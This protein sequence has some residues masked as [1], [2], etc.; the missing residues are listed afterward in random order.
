MYTRSINLDFANQQLPEHISVMQGDSARKILVELYR[1]NVEWEV[2]G[3]VSAYIAFRRPDGKNLK[4]TSLSDGSPVVSLYDNMATISV[5]VE[6]TA[7]HG[8]VPLVVVFVD[9][10]GSQIATFPIAI[11]VVENPAVES[12]L[13]SQLTPKE[14]D[15]LLVEITQTNA[16]INELVASHNSEGAEEYSLDIYGDGNAYITIRSNGTTAVCTV[17]DNAIFG[18]GAVRKYQ[19][20]ERFAPPIA[21]YAYDG[22]VELCI[23]DSYD[24]YTEVVLK[25]KNQSEAKADGIW[26]QFVYALAAVYTPKELLDVRVGADGTIYETAG[27]AV[28]E[29]MKAASTGSGGGGANVGAV[30]YTKQSPTPEQQAQARENI[31]AVGEEALS[32]FRT[33]TITEVEI[34]GSTNIFN[35]AAVIPNKKLDGAAV[36]DSTTGEC[37]SETFKV[38]DGETDITLSYVTGGGVHQL[39]TFI[40]AFYDSEMKSI[41][42]MMAANSKYTIPDNAAYFI[43]NLGNAFNSVLHRIMVQYG[44]TMTAFESYVAPEISTVEEVRIKNECLDFAEITESRNQYNFETRTDDASLNTDGTLNTTDFKNL[45][46]V[47]YFIPCYGESV[48]S[49]SSAADG[50]YCF[51]DANKSFISPYGVFS[52]GKEGIAIPA[53][54]HYVRV[55]LLKANALTFVLSFTEAAVP[56]EKYGATYTSIESSRDKNN[57]KSVI[58]DILAS[59]GTIKFLGDSITQ[60]VGGTGFAQDGEEIREGWNVNTKGY[61]FANLFKTY[62]ETKYSNPVINY[63]TKGVRSYNLVSWLEA[64]DGYVTEDDKLLIVMIGTNNKWS[65]TADTLADLKN[66]IQWIV[67]WCAENGKKLILVSAPMSTVGYDTQYSDGTAV[68]FHNEDIDH[69]YKEVC[70]KNNMDYVPMY[71]RMV[72]YCDLKD[73]DIATIFDD[74]LH[75]NDKGYYIMYK[76]LM[77]ELGLAYQMPNSDWDNASPSA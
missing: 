74:G 30:L 55:S 75:P 57:C 27:E 69:V 3:D 17:S 1:N 15:Q 4:I 7:M 18:M 13:A 32:E 16:R 64:K 77:K 73:I 46:S 45:R 24:G 68:K 48:F 56:Y 53:T 71:Q 67:D 20:P 28:R 44:D 12:D 25:N 41:V 2:P 66:D 31:G 19:L 10:N 36:V 65:T 8:A 59:G 54:A 60:G 34:G 5:P 42:P 6:V 37:V 51:Y 50:V 72:E 58:S 70:H 29:Q 43:V 23:S 35:P 76:L 40:V 39:Q 49:A 11:S 61:C 63:G 38:K 26:F 14:F 52:N 47:S 62:I 22:D 33:K 21:Y 9:S